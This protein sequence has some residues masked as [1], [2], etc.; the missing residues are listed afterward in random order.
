M[1]YQKSIEKEIQMPR[2]LQK[3]H[4]ASDRCN[5]IVCGDNKLT[6]FFFDYFYMIILV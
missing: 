1:L 5:K 6:L 4:V 3:S 2:D